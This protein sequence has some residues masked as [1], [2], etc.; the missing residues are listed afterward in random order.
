MLN[1]ESHYSWKTI[2]KLVIFNNFTSAKELSPVVNVVNLGRSN[3][4]KRKIEPVKMRSF[5]FMNEL[6]SVIKDTNRGRS[7]MIIITVTY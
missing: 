5:V 6:A 1:E 2:I 3:Q 7:K 4:I